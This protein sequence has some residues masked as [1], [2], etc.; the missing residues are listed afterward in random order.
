[1]KYKILAIIAVGLLSGPI[2][3]L[4]VLVESST[5]VF[6]SFRTCVAG[7]TSACDIPPSAPISTIA[8]LPGN[9][10][11]QADATNAEFGMTSGSTEL[12]DG[13]LSASATSLSLKR[14]GSTSATTQR[15][16]YGFGPHYTDLRC[17]AEVRSD[18][19]CGE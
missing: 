9:V 6:L 14:N 10:A 11:T 18:G 1:M 7:A 2:A 4:A 8:G 12:V 15:Y 13:T 5:T 17:Q 16:T 3:A 19:A